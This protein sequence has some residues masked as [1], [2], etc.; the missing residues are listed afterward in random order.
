KE[1]Q[2]SVNFLETRL[3]PREYYNTKGSIETNGLGLVGVQYERQPDTGF[4]FAII[5]FPRDFQRLTNQEGQRRKR[6]TPAGYHV[7]L[8]YHNDYTEHQLARAAIY[9]FANT[10][11][12]YQ[13]VMVPTFSVS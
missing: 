1:H 8:G 12:N 13:T 10:Y 2:G 9:N 7:T 4:H 6:A 11:I 5:Y 3:P